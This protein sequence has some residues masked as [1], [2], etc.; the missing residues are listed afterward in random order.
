MRPKT[1][2]I[3]ILVS[4]LAL[5]GLVFTQVLWILEETRLA[6]KQFNHRAD[7]ALSDV[8]GELKTNHEAVAVPVDSNTAH[9]ILQVVDTAF[10]SGLM[11]KYVNYHRLE[12]EYYYSIVKSSN[13]SVVW[14]SAGFSDDS[15]KTEPFKACL[16]P[17][18][19]GTY[20]HLALYFPGK[21]RIVFSKQIGWILLTLIFLTIISSGVILIVFTYLRQKKLSEMKNDFINNVTHEFKT[22]VATIALAAE[23]LMKSDPRSGQERVKNY[24]RIILDEN[25]RMKKQIERVLEIAQQDHQEITLNLQ[26][27]DVHKTISSVIPNICL[28]RSEKEVSVN[29]NLKAKNPVIRGDMMFLTGV[30]T[31][32]TENALKYNNRQPEIRVDTEDANDGILISI[33][34]NGIGMS[35]EA[36]KHIFN[37]FYRVPT[38]NIHNVKGFGLGLYYARIMTEAHGGYINVFSDLNKG[39]RFDVYFPYSAAEK[40]N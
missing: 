2:K 22:P 16:S 9:N 10:L 35:R 36:M 15:K 23:V 11:R 12:G 24:A 34:D 5:L 4:L 17:V 37:K 27:C 38:G 25:E 3:I 19:K 33:T 40:R 6:G 8:I 14:H 7:N 39:S 30:I 26:E 21:N 18:Y 29:Y 31:N 1:V 32:I 28:E 20:Y 13:D